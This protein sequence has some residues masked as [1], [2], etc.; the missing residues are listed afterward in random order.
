MLSTFEY[1]VLFLFSFDIKNRTTKL[2]HATDGSIRLSRNRLTPPVR[3]STDYT[4][5]RAK[6][7]TEY[8]SG[9]SVERNKRGEINRASGAKDDL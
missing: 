8:D 7:M 9:S 6:G 5:N 2:R 1:K 3:A 4:N